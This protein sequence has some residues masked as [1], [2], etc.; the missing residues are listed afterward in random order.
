[1]S[2][3]LADGGDGFSVFRDATDRT[4][5]PIDIDAFVAYLEKSTEKSPLPA[6][7]L[8]RVLGDACE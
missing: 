8:E 1:M 5:G 3:F 2:S 6:P 7:K 4:P